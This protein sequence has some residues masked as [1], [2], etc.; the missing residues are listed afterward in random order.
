MTGKS[1]AHNP[2]I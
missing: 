2:S 1:H